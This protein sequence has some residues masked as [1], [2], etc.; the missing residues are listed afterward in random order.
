MELTQEQEYLLEEMKIA[1]KYCLWSRFS[2]CQNALLDLDII[3]IS[4]GCG[5]VMFKEIEYE[6]MS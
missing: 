6:K 5:R 4:D 3:A 2:A 1:M